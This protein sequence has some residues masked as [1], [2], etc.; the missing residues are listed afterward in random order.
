MDHGYGYG[1]GTYGSGNFWSRGLVSLKSI[2]WVKDQVHPSM[3]LSEPQSLSLSPPVRLRPLNQDQA[4][5][6]T[7]FPHSLTFQDESSSVDG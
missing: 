2:L 6:Y 4:T 7:R 5:F 3:D 1:Y